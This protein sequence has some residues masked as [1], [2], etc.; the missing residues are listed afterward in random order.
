WWK[1]TDKRIHLDIDELNDLSQIRYLSVADFEQIVAQCNRLL[2]K[3]QDV[4]TTFTR[5]SSP[6][7]GFATPNDPQTQTP[8]SSG[9]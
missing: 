2:H 4:L 5:P 3:L 9:T 7:Q 1:Q 6:A 8:D